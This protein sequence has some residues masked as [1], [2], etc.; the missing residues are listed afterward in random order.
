MSPLHLTGYSRTDMIADPS[1]SSQMVQNSMTPQTLQ[2][3]LDFIYTVKTPESSKLLLLTNRNEYTSLFLVSLWADAHQIRL[4]SW[5]V[6]WWKNSNDF[7]NNVKQSLIHYLI[8]QRHHWYIRQKCLMVQHQTF[9]TFLRKQK[10]N[11]IL[12][13]CWP[14]ASGKV[15]VGFSCILE[16]LHHQSILLSPLFHGWWAR[17]WQVLMGTKI[18]SNHFYPY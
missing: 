17:F 6:Q 12:L 18:P 16:H 11:I 2:I 5:L 8:Q 15:L 14:G 3:S 7:M 4:Y 1:A 13:P 10:Q 9:E